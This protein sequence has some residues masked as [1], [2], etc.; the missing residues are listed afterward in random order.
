MDKLVRFQIGESV[1]FKFDRGGDSISG[2]T[3]TITVKKFPTGADL[4]VPR[5]IPADD[6]A[7][8]GFLTNSE[9]SSFVYGGATGGLHYLIATLLNFEND[10]LEQIPIRMSVTIAWA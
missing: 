3:C 10:E 4:I 5:E 7:W 6:D 9:T 1:P 2:W 8:P